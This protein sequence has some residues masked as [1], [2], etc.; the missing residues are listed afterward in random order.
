M[1]SERG[2]LLTPFQKMLLALVGGLALILLG[3]GTTFVLGLSSGPAASVDPT[4]APAFLP[5]ATLPEA[6]ISPALTA[7]TPVWTATAEIAP[8]ACWPTS[9]EQVQTRVTKVLD[10]NTIEVEL[11]GKML[12]V[13]YL[14]VDLPASAGE[15]NDFNRR[16]V[17]GQTVRLVK[18]GPDVDR[19]GHLLRYV[20]LGDQLVSYVLV[21]QGYA[22]AALYPPGLSCTEM[23]LAAQ[24]QAEQERLGFWSQDGAP[25][26]T[27]SALPGLSPTPPCDCGRKYVCTDFSHQAAAQACYNACGDYRNA[28]LDPDHN[29]LACEE[30]PK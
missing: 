19:E 17:E 27:L 9:A 3:L 13:R 28:S 21:R 10:G 30:L 14:G 6:A 25:A 7:F 8:Q 4:D 23:L 1:K 15:G 26:P 11:N 2:R 22:I 5:S 20:L 18:D 16:L 24:R 29:G 12:Q